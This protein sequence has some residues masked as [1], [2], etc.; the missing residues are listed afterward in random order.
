MTVKKILINEDNEGRRIDNFL[1][2]IFSTVPKSKIYNIIRKGEVRV[3]SSRK[4]PN[5]KPIRFK[6]PK[7]YKRGRLLKSGIIQ[8]MKVS[9]TG[10]RYWN[11]IITKIDRP[12]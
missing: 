2:S 10:R 3:N 6:K 12:D 5:Y 7:P 1:I 11:P 9:I 8:H 4:K